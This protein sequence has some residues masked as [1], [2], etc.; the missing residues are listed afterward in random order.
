MKFP[1]SFQ[2]LI[3]IVFT[4]VLLTILGV[5]SS[6]V[7]AVSSNV[8]ISEF[9]VRG[10]NG[11]SDEFIELY[12]LSSSPVNIGGWKINGSNAS[13]TTNTRVTIT[14]G[15]VLNPGCFYLLTN[16]STSGGPYSGSVPGDQTYG[17]GI[18][19]DG[20]I[21]LLMPD[22]T[23]VDQ[24]GMS[25]GS[26]YKEG[27][28]L[29]NLG[30]SNL[31]RSYE[32]KPGG[33]L[34]HNIDTDNNSND[35]QLLSPSNPQNSSSPCIV[36]DTAPSVSSITPAN[37]AT[38][39]A[40]DANIMVTF[41]EPV[42]VS[43]TWF[44][45]SCTSGS[46]TATVS[47]GPTTFTLNPDS[48][49]A[50]GDSC[51]VTIIAAQVSDQDTNDP[52][53]TMTANFVS[54]FSV[55]GVCD[56][57]YTPI[58][59][60]QGSGMSAAITGNVA[61]KGVVIGDYE[62]ASPA[63]RGFYIQDLTGDG[64][65][66]T[67]DGIFVFNGNNNNVNLG[68][69]V[70]VAGT[71]AEFQDQT[72]ISASSITKCGTGSITPVNVT[73]PFPDLNYAERFEGMLV[74][75]PQTLYVTE[76]FQLGRFGQVVLSAGARLQ[77]PTNVVAPG[78]PALAMQAQNDLNRIIVDDEL[79]N[80]NPDPIRFGRGGNPLSAS[81]TLRGG[82]TVTNLVGVMT[83]TWSWNAASGNAYRVRPV[84]AMGGGVPNFVAANARP[85]TPASVS[86]TLKVVGM[87]LLNYFNTFGTGACTLGVGGAP[88]DCRGAE[89]TTEFDRQTAKTIAAIVA[90]NPDILGVNEIEND[91]Y[92][93]TSAIQDLVNRLNNAMGAGT[94]AFI[95]VDART[96]QV[97]ALGTD[98][99]KVGLLYK[100]SKVTPL[101]T[102]A[103]NSVAF[104]NGGDSA[105]RN[106]PSLAQAFEQNSNKA[107][108][109][110]NVNH[111]KSKGS[112]C[113]APDAGDGQGNCN[114]VRTNAA[115]V[116]AS[117]LATDPTGV[118]DPDILI[119]GDLNSY[120]K[121]DPVTA[122]KNAGFTNLIETKIGASAYSYVFDG[123]WGYLDYALGSPSL[124]GQVT[125]V[126]EYHINAD[127]PS[128]LDYNTNF[129]SAGQIVSLYAPDQYRVSD[130]DPVIVGL[131]L[132][133]P[134]TVS[135]G[136][137]YSVNEGSSVTVTATGNDPDGDPLTYAW[138]LDNNGS[139][140]TPGQGV[141][142]SAAT[143]D[144][145]A[146]RTIKVKATDP[147][148]LYA[149]AQ[150]TVTINNVAPAMSANPASQNVQYSDPIATVTVTAKDVAAD[151]PPTSVKTSWK[152][153]T[154]ASFTAGLPS[155][156]T[157]AS[158]TCNTTQC[159]WT[160]NGKAMLAPATYI[161]RITATDKDGGSAFVDIT[162]VV[163]QED[164]RATYTGALF[165]S[166]SSPSS[167][168]ANVTLAATVQDITAV[169][170]GSDPNPGDIRNATLTFV[171]RDAGNAVL[172]TAPIGLVNSTDIKTGTG[173]CTWSANLGTADSLS[174]NVGIVVNGY[175]TRN[176]AEDNVVVTVSKPLA[177]DFITGGGYLVL[178]NSAGEK[179]GAPGSKANF[180]F[181]VKFNPSGKNLQGNINII[182]RNG[183]RVYQIKG[184][185]MTSLA[186]QPTPCTEATAT[187]PCTATFNGKANIQDI[188][189]P[190]N[191][192]SVDGNA[193]LQVTMTDKGE[194]GSSDSIGITVWNKNG[195]LWF[196]SKWDGAKTIEQILGGGNLVVH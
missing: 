160:L 28:P 1:F 192:V 167:S 84:N 87:N 103:L 67:S 43:G 161:V 42:N 57:P 104:V 27:T 32:R 148:G 44:T 179:A 123:Q 76:H 14:S 56:L 131:K 50:A 130:H 45:I 4:L 134:P 105:P 82:D 114:I 176:S 120:A 122:L 54:T 81:N 20:G 121:E 102:A 18:T 142:F 116:L 85:T 37:S 113:D 53:D 46:R 187:A 188:T 2:R 39:V 181:N 117:W 164:A 63:L 94:F 25:T 95:D 138:D 52:P 100:P 8:V 48:D 71:A 153:S 156:W 86:G 172:C 13:G 136:G 107:R 38:N 196:A 118:G 111:L 26:A 73:L 144:G 189:D 162:F 173:T 191:P 165:V 163:K 91:G 110:V 129:K 171:N 108:F 155:G 141:S 183:G 60:I 93:P 78:A 30:T 62:G 106:R 132:N 65:S 195:G 72:Q 47:G 119:I 69:L 159:T 139:F 184:N 58:Y 68:D 190:N 186:V 51:T 92:G 16:S 128:V 124:N 99:I 182:V 177:S 158:A 34:G 80:Q 180:G 41:S 75:F 35:F 115:N 178:T 166:T 126:T 74:K 17:T 137:P 90:M 127:E 185:A 194:P 49:F 151:L 133:G 125:G 174:I 154:D 55:I 147:S 193:T 77:Q 168:T 61:T 143:I 150:T 10:P 97:N 64:D 36:G 15:T 135:A 40:L 145:P 7:Q 157:L 59:Q 83:Y 101:G 175:Y 152:K 169:D 22:N 31:N 112:A 66:A 23:I 3:L 9:R 70:R 6:P 21:A 79:N 96:G 11:G 19:D 109:V 33:S 12:N 29:A 5:P 88:T 170:S 146:T 149:T 140:E 89:N 24:V 98:A